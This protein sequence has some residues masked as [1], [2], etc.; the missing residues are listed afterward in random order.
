MGI[1]WHDITHYIGTSKHNWTCQRK[2][3]LYHCL[4]RKTFFPQDS[5]YHCP[6][7]RRKGLWLEHTYIFACLTMF[8]FILPMCNMAK[9]ALE[10]PLMFSCTNWKA[11]SKVKSTQSLWLRQYFQVLFFFFWIMPFWMTLHAARPQKHI[12]QSQPPQCHRPWLLPVAINLS[13]PQ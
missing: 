10:N 13:R 3:C 2:T 11:Q 12:E 5:R 4:C 7:W 8:F 6:Q 1:S 9:M